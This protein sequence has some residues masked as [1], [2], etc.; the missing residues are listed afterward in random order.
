MS[1]C[2]LVLRSG[3]DAAATLPTAVNKQEGHY[4]EATPKRFW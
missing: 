1:G 3:C 2:G 4:K